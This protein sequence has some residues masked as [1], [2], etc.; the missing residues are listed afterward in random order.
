VLLLED[1][2]SRRHFGTGDAGVESLLIFARFE[3]A[4]AAF[5]NQFKLTYKEQKIK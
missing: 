2:K 1:K 4:G 3:L 5:G